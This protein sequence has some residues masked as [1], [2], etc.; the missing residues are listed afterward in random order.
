MF[1]PKVGQAILEDLMED[2]NCDRYTALQI[3][4]DWDVLP[5]YIDGQLVASMIHSG[6]EVHF[7][8]AK[9]ARGKVINRTRMREFL[10]P[11]F[12]EKGF[13]T[14]RLLHRH[15]GPQRFIERIGFKKTWSDENFNYFMLTELPFERKHN[16]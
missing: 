9:E 1:D 11:L 7:A 10:R 5:G 3:L 4:H 8:I 15:K 12:E 6:T 2:L 13:L 14:T 16:V